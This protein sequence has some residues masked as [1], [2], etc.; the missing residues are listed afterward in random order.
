[1]PVPEGWE[2][3]NDLPKEWETPPELLEPTG[4]PEANLV[5]RIL[6]SEVLGH[7]VRAAVGRFVTE[8]ALFTIWF[9]DN[10]KRSDRG[11]KESALLSQIP[12][13]ETQNVYE[14]WKIFED[15]DELD[16]PREELRNRRVAAAAGL[17]TALERAAERLARV[18]DGNVE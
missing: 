16:A 10:V 13:E 15:V 9:F 4:D 18:R 8:H 14:A 7:E 1:M 3:L 12:A 6:S 2:W 5:I 11:M 17:T